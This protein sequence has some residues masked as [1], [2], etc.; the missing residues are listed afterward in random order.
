MKAILLA[1]LLMMSICPPPLHAK[2]AETNFEA[3]GDAFRFLP[4]Y[5]MVVSVAIEDYWGV[6]ELALGTLTGQAITEGI[7][8]GMNTLYDNGYN[9]SFAKRPCCDTWKGMPS[10]HASGAFSA[11]GFVF[12]RY[13]WK[14]AIPTTILATLVAASRVEARKHSLL[15]VS[16]GALIGW[17]S[18]WIFTKK[19]LPENTSVMPVIDSDRQGHISYGINLTY[20]F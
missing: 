12:Y 5:V 4:L 18:A 3:F 1:F 16:V 11:A 9:V 19:Y 13:G 6:G 17:G 7:R 15:Q 2:T 20:R 10:G 14:P 8:W